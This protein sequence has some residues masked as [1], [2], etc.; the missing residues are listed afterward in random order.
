[1]GTPRISA[2]LPIDVEL[3]PKALAAATEAAR[4][5]P[6]DELIARLILE[7]EVAT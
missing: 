5:H 1:V 2:R 3:D 6:V 4:A 7:P